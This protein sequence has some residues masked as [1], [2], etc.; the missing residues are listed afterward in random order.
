MT[1]DSSAAIPSMPSH[2]LKAR[3]NLARRIFS[4]HFPS[5]WTGTYPTSFPS[6]TS[7]FSIAFADRAEDELIGFR[8]VC[9]RAVEENGDLHT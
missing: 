5:W 1:A 9:R 8:G 7:D 4:I 3:S 2:M 6:P